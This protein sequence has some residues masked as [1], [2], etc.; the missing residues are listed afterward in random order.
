MMKK[1]SKRQP[2]CRF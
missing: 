2:S 1:D